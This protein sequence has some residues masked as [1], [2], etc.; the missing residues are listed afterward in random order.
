MLLLLI[1][2]ASSLFVPFK[3][4]ILPAIKYLNETTFQTYSPSRKVLIGLILS[5][6]SPI[7]QQSYMLSLLASVIPIYSNSADFVFFRSDAL[8]DEIQKLN[9]VPPYLA[10]FI[11]KHLA[12]LCPFPPT[13]SALAFFIGSYLD[14]DIDYINSEEELFK[15][16]AGVPFAILVREGREYRAMAANFNENETY[17]LFL[18][19]TKILTLAL[20]HIGCC[21]P[22]RITDKLMSK[23]MHGSECSKLN[24]SFFRAA[25]NS[26]VPLV[27][28]SNK[29]IETMFNS[30]K[31]FY[32]ELDEYLVTHASDVYAAYIAPNEISVNNRK[33]ELFL[34]YNL[35]N[36]ERYE[37]EFRFVIA[38]PHIYPYVNQILR[39]EVSSPDFII[40]SYVEGYFYPNGGKL[41]GISMED[42]RWKPLAKQYIDDVLN[43][44]ID[45]KYFSEKVTEKY[46]PKLNKRVLH[47]LVG[48]TYEDFVKTPNVDVC[49]MYIDSE[50]SEHTKIALSELNSTIDRLY[51]EPYQDKDLNILFGY[52]NINENSSPLKYPVIANI[53]Q[54]MLFPSY[55][56]DESCIM[57]SNF[58][59]INFDRFLNTSISV[60]A[61]PGRIPHVP[62]DK[63]S[64]QMELFYFSLRNRKMPPQYQNDAFKYVMYLQSYLSDSD[65]KMPDMGNMHEFMMPPRND[66]PHQNYDDL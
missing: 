25:D 56:K 28:D 6:E 3:R 5:S 18:Q 41:R 59:D 40:F 42:E 49:V 50:N 48:S 34:T 33:G 32:S 15:S 26:I 64:A 53:P 58:D 65:S 22:I 8:P 23:I 1:S 54:F 13:E 11:D 36:D 4:T 20:P 35:S 63:M 44:K 21:I 57:L 66:G 45:R 7:D 46:T 47:K 31:P 17:N 51:R 2:L 29:T 43:H 19:A 62:L 60:E 9:I 12:F 39:S 27:F 30:T 52:I 55:N 10:F 24:F 38:H 61:E 16:L 14:R 37:K